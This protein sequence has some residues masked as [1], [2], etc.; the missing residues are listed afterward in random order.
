ME[1]ASFDGPLDHLREGEIK[2]RA[3]ENLQDLESLDN[4][5]KRCTSECEKIESCIAS[6]GT[7]PQRTRELRAWKKQAAEV[8]QKKRL[9]FELQ[10]G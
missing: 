10:A 3:G 8:E 1:A 2:E 4:W 5:L 9:H 6:H 7:T